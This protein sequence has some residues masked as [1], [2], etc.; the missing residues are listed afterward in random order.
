MTWCNDPDP[1]SI[2]SKEVQKT[3]LVF[4]EPVYQ[5]A[6][7]LIIILFAQAWLLLT[8]IMVTQLETKNIHFLNFPLG[9]YVFRIFFCRYSIMVSRC[10]S[11]IVISKFFILN[12]TD[13]KI[14]GAKTSSNWFYWK[15][16]KHE[17]TAFGT[18]SNHLRTR[19]PNLLIFVPKRK[20]NY[21]HPHMM[22]R[23]MT[24]DK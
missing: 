19:W 15:L 11:P 6:G 23:E 1:K 22:M 10:R 13:K 20:P 3:A 4:Q 5:W 18:P 16:L 14:R 8:S 2:E 21:F 9:Y 24:N 17:C 7:R 12:I